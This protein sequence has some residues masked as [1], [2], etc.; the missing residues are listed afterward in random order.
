LA[1][2]PEDRWRTLSLLLDD[3]L[4]L[5]GEERDRRLQ[6]IS[7]GD[8][9]LGAELTDLLARQTAI[10]QGGFLEGQALALAPAP[11]LA[12]TALGG[13]TLVRPLGQGGM[14]TVWLAR[15]SDGRF[16][17]EA[18]IKLLNL[19]LVGQAGEE[20]FEREGSILARLAHPHIARLLDAGVSPG[21]QPYLVLEHVEGEPID[22]SCDA[23]RLGVEARLRLFL[24]V[25]AA[26]AHAHANLIVHRDLK[27]S[28]VLVRKDGQVKLLDFGIA[29][30]LEGGEGEA[31]ALTRDGGQA[32][33]PSFAAP[34]QITGG[35]VT[36]A[37]DVHAL[38]TLLYLLLA[39]R[40]P[41]EDAL[42]SPAE[43]VKAIVDGSP[44]RLSDAVAGSG[45]PAER[46]ATRAAARGT[47]PEALRR[48]LRGDLD[49][50]VARALKKR[51]EERYPSVA[52][53]GD[54]VRR[55]LEDEP[56]AARPDSLSYRGAKFLRR[57]RRG[58]AAAAAVVLLLAGL[59]G[60][61]TV[62]LA[63]ERDRA[64][65]EAAKSAKVSELLTGLL[66]GADPYAIKQGKEPG[67][68]DI[69]EAGARRVRDELGKQPELQAE[70]LAVIGRIYSRLGLGE[71]ARPLL[72]Q[73]L[74]TA[75]RAWGPESVQVARGLNDLGA[76]LREQGEYPEA[77]RMLEEALAMRRRLLGPGHEDVAVTLVELG[78][79]YD[80]QGQ[81]ARAE[82]LFREAL[83]IRRKALGEEDHETATSMNELALLLWRK[84]D[85]AGAEALFR[86]CLEIDRKLDGPDHPDVSTAL[87]NLALVSMER[88]NFAGAESLL[89]EAVAVGR[90]ALGNGHPE[91]AQK[92]YNL[93]SALREQGK[94]EEAEAAIREAL[95][96]AVPARGEHHP[97]VALY[98]MGLAR[99][100]LARGQ[101]AAA[102]PPLRQ[103]LGSL[104]ASLP[105][106]DRRVAAAMSLLG[107]DLTRLGRYPEA[108]PLL[109]AAGKVLKAGPGPEGREARANAGRLAALEQAR[110]RAAPGGRAQPRP[111]GSAPGQ[112]G[113]GG[114]PRAAATSA[115]P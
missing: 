35:P 25:I 101:A 91:M 15:R 94:L 52:A 71:T 67:V 27:P 24:D 105:D 11:A 6:E 13:Y 30:L 114:P 106:S 79:V 63:A 87:N 7:R 88:G 48:A 76:Q 36:T 14:G 45:G 44:R 1:A 85:L 92:L 78:R 70:M 104:R 21:G 95:A 49:T 16:E 40:H 75:R 62:R 19:G 72:E 109:V 3:L 20:R 2:D 47:S 64:R 46:Q 98:R 61:Y 93:S 112:R 107:D 113:R 43:L 37:T 100:L 96:I 55:Y 111:R 9:G 58:V 73:A 22:R 110:S 34:E 108:E 59:V 97:L 83:A 68:R 57:H 103:A 102:E 65:I 5:A 84:G 4:D 38:G 12:G 42:R 74:A 115:N 32:L 99:V 51:P 54:D 28:N 17:G 60:F 8:P 10:E 80:D 69:L 86:R 53:L 66:A 39:G 56:I 81:A 23:R 50:I 26:V 18:A 41:A 89:R 77:A 82:P 90:K 31:T 33:T 29:K